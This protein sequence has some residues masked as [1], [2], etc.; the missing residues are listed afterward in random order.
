MTVL[1]SAAEA[2]PPDATAP[3]GE[4]PSDPGTER[5]ASETTQNDPS[6]VS[7]SAARER[8]MSWRM[9]RAS[10]RSGGVVPSAASVELPSDSGQERFP[11]EREETLAGFAPFRGD[12]RPATGQHPVTE[13]RGVVVPVEKGGAPGREEAGSVDPAEHGD[14]V[15]LEPVELREIAPR[16]VA[17]PVVRRRARPVE[18]QVPVLREVEDDVARRHARQSRTAQD[19]FRP[20]EPKRGAAEPVEKRVE[21]DLLEVPTLELRDGQAAPQ[22]AVRVR[23]RAGE[24]IPPRASV[25]RGGN[26]VGCVF[27]TD[28]PGDPR[29]AEGLALPAASS[30]SGSGVARGD[31]TEQP[32]LRRVDQADEIVDEPR[33]VL[34]EHGTATDAV[35]ERADVL[36][37]QRKLAIERLAHGR[38]NRGRG[39]RGALGQRKVEHDPVGIELLELDQAGRDR[40][41][42]PRPCAGDSD[43][44]VVHVEQ[45]DLPRC[46]RRRP[47]PEHHIVD[48][49]GAGTGSLPGPGGGTARRTGGVRETGGRAAWLPFPEDTRTVTPSR[50]GRANLSFR[51]RQC[52][53][54]SSGNADAL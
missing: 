39:G 32:G 52:V 18:Q 41:G 1:T 46:R 22:H 45:E 36:A 48:P 34:R 19:E 3:R 15:L 7:R 17:E 30:A 40:L 38:R 13:V 31:P 29:P 47:Q 6:R 53:D 49:A 33:R 43:G 23:H 16:Q 4:R 10:A 54:I 2:E 42:W 20:I 37:D 26:G 24:A 12:G 51:V 44:T 27:G 8:R 5:V 14:Q 35:E 28:L 50:K 25:E 21:R 11:G 9:R